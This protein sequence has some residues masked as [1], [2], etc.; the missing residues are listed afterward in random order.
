MEAG[1]SLTC[2]LCR[3]GPAVSVRIIDTHTPEQ[4]RGVYSVRVKLLSTNDVPGPL[5]RADEGT[6]VILTS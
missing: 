4:D 2:T 6:A 3:S 5:V 1:D